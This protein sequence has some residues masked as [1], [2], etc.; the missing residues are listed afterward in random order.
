M[1][2]N[3]R[4]TRRIIAWLICFTMFVTLQNV[5]GLTI[6][7]ASAA[8]EGQQVTFSK[9]SGYYAQ[10][11]NLTLTAPAGHT[12]YYTT[13][14]SNPVPGNSNTKKYSGAIS[15]VNKKNTS[16]VLSNSSNSGKY[17]D[18]GYSNVPSKSELDRAAIIRAVAVSDSTGEVSPISTRTY[19][20]GNNIKTSYNGCA[21]MSIVTD[22]T[23]LLDGK[24][25]I[26]V[27]GD[28]YYNSYDIKD[29]NFMQKG[30]DWER[31]AYMEFFNGENTADIS[32]GVGI[33]IHGGY[34]RRNQ[35]KSFNIYF[36]ADYDYGTKNL[37]GYEL[38]P[39]SNTIYSGSSAESKPI[40]KYAN[41]M[42]RNG[43]ND[44]DIT[45]FQ[46][47]FIQSMLTDKNFTTQCSRPCMLYLNGEYW[48]LYNLTE[49]YSDKYIEEK[50]GVDNNNVIVYK[51]LEI[52]E[53]EALDPDGKALS[54]LMALG[55]LDMTKAANYQKFQDM[56]DIDSYVDY[57]A[58]E[59]Y[60][61]NNDWWS[62][63]N[64]ET[65][66][67]NIQFWKVADTSIED[68][69][70][71]YADGKWRYMLYD[72]E[73]SMGIY[74][75]NEASAR[76]DSIKNHAIGA[77][78]N[79]NGDP[80]FRALMK[81]T[82]FQE[83]LTNAILD[84]RNWNFEYNRASKALDEFAN[85]YTPL[86]SKH[87]VRWNVGN[88]SSGVRT[89]K[90]FLSERD[91]YVFEMLEN[92]ISALKSSGRVNVNVSANISGSDYIKVN[93]VVPDISSTWNAVY[94]K[95]YP[96]KVSAGKADGYTFDHWNVTGATVSDEKSADATIT[97]TSDKAAVQ[98][99]YK[100]STGVAPVPTASPV[101]TATPAPTKNPWGGGG[102]W[103][104]D[105]PTEKP[106]VKPTAAP[107]VT[108]T[109]TP[110]DSTPAPTAAANTS[111]PKDTSGTPSA[112]SEPKTIGSQ[113]GDDTGTFAVGNFEYKIVNDNA[114]ITNVSDVNITSLKIATA[115]TINNTSYKVTG[116]NASVFK[117]CKNLKS[118]VIGK[119]VQIIGKNAFAGC[120]KLKKITIKSTKLKKIGKNAFKGINK[121]AVIRIPKSKNKTYKKLLKKGGVKSPVRIKN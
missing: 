21:V 117:K 120:S 67:N 72:T 96:V 2:K 22:S 92:N 18:S 39:G 9:E 103:D 47:V 41:V 109:R 62:G 13:D 4:F 6:S 49:K 73:W 76:Y 121:K 15:I 85:I 115:V 66:H 33:R 20:I 75:S 112:S 116:I 105:F 102:W 19:F 14:C 118:V 52:D 100:D 93:S 86:M 35:Q 64:D 24:N 113:S 17:T 65:P 79:Y 56:V 54:E 51:D 94:Y 5:S 38:I 61:N 16:P 46:D 71:P 44:V 77:D 98:A 87:S 80:V 45:K 107:T 88:V 42:L 82:D 89:M 55:N 28:N 110:S 50:F 74:N 8:G 37:K 70:N 104:W 84:I 12:V 69:S 3:N 111:V 95:N 43:G 31:S 97:L 90:N 101:P 114:V 36:R 26:Y 59:I 7:T 99:V 53:G 40:G 11:F 29:A 10:S 108:P 68:A 1:H 60:I 81:N 25:G 119:H 106:T 57:C 27:L 58:A 91:D 48:G 83:R 34:S 23:N 78:N 63:C 32:R 30:R